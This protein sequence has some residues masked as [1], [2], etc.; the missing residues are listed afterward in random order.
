MLIIGEWGGGREGEGGRGG[1]NNI[2]LGFDEIPIA[3]IDR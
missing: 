2:H 3:A 1:G